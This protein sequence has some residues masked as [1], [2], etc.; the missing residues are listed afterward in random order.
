MIA[1]MFSEPQISQEDSLLERRCVVKIE[2]KIFLY[3]SKV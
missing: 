1:L 2:N 3:R